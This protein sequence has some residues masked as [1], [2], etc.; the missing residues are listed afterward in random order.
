MY[1]T[2][3]SDT[4]IAGNILIEITVWKVFSMEKPP[5]H[6]Q[7]ELGFHPPDEGCSTYYRSLT[8]AV[9]TLSDFCFWN[10]LSCQS[11]ECTNCIQK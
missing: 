9:H 8:M 1:Y 3:K 2:K 4:N 10:A 7:A 5:D 11:I 6:L